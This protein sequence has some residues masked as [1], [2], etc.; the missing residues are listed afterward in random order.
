MTIQFLILKHLANLNCL[1]FIKVGLNS[2]VIIFQ[3]GAWAD[4]KFDDIQNDLDC[5]IMGTQY[6]YNT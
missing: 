5:L 3:F 1:V 2:E 6:I 4:K